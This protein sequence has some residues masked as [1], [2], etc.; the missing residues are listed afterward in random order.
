MTRDGSNG[1]C[2][3]SA[4]RLY[5]FDPQGASLVVFDTP[6]TKLGPFRNPSGVAL[7]PNGE[8]YVAD[9]LNHRILRLAWE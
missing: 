9:T 1:A 5:V 4:S 2:S 6:S 7:G 3:N 8:I